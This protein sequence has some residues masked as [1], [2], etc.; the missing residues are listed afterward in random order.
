[1]TDFETWL[2]DFG[3]DVIFRVT[4]LKNPWQYTPY[5]MKMDHTSLSLKYTNNDYTYIQILEV[6][7]LPDKNILIGYKVINCKDDLFKN[8][9]EVPRYYRKL[10]DIKLSYFPE[11][12]ICSNWE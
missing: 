11:D 12:Q 6:I 2:Y 9:D 1:M 5:E 8:D 10:S 4:E 3:Y 7:E